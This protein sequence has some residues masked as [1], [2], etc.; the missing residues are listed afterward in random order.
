MTANIKCGIP[1]QQAVGGHIPYFPDYKAYLKAF[2]FLKKRLI[3][4][5]ALYVD[6]SID[7]EIPFSTAPCASI[8]RLVS[9]V[10][11]IY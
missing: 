8:M 4:Q 5:C 9:P 7:F 11:L 1:L 10:R 2:N 3:V 6:H